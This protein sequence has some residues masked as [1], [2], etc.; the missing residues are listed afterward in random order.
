MAD[1]MEE[2]R[3]L[4]QNIES[5]KICGAITT[6]IV[7]DCIKGVDEFI[8]KFPDAAPS[9]DSLIVAA[10]VKF[11]YQ[12]IIYCLFNNHFIFTFH[13]HISRSC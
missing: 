12:I 4:V 5:I 9:R 8:K 10:A 1:N 7:D 6:Q 13:N 3:K 2:L 11:T